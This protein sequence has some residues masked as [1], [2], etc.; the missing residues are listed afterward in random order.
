MWTERGMKKKSMIFGTGHKSITAVLQ[1]MFYGT[2][3]GRLSCWSTATGALRT[4]APP[5]NTSPPSLLLLFGRTLWTRLFTAQAAGF[6]LKAFT[7]VFVDFADP[8][9]FSVYSAFSVP[10][11]FACH[12]SRPYCGV[13]L[14]TAVSDD[15]GSIRYVYL[16]VSKSLWYCSRITPSVLTLSVMW[17]PR[18]S[19]RSTESTSSKAQVSKGMSLGGYPKQVG[20]IDWA[21]GVSWSECGR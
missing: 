4:R 14:W 13:G 3:P 2:M 19:S 7:F 16:A 6:F 15:V 12:L 10:S 21:S 8:F 20:D 17:Q 9:F 11:C 18:E 5:E 1:L